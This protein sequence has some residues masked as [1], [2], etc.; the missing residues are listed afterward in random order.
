MKSINFYWSALLALTI[1]VS[2]CQNDEFLAPSGETVP[3][4]SVSVQGTT[5]PQTVASV[6]LFAGQTTDV[7][8]LDLTEVDTDKDGLNDAVSVTYSLTNGWLISE[9]HFWAGVTLA[10]MPQ[11]KNG[12]PQI[13]KFPY[14]I[15]EASGMSSYTLVIPFESLNY[16]DCE[17]TYVAAAHASVYSGSRKETA[18]AA[19]TEMN[20]KGSWATYFDFTLVDNNPPVVIGSLDEVTVEGCSALDV[21]EAAA[22]ISELEA[23]GLNVSDTRTPAE[24]LKVSSNDSENGTCPIVVTRTYTITDDCGNAT[25]VKQTIFVEDTTAPVLSGVGANASITAPAEPG[26][27]APVTSDECGGEV[28]LTSNDEVVISA[29]ETVITRTWTATDACGNSAFASQT[30]T[31]VN[32]DGQEFN[33]NSLNNTG[34]CTYQTETAFGGETAGDGNAWWFYFDGKGIQTI[35]AG[36]HYNVGTVE[37]KDGYL[38]I[39]LTDGWQ[40]QDVAESVKIQGYTSVP[41]KRPAAG[42]FTTYKGVALTV[43]VDAYPYYVIHLDVQKC[44]GNN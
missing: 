25:E 13:G 5:E 15:A 14:N 29:T 41:S 17:A 1:I 31:V 11:T 8:T 42:Q 23:L 21:P 39:S 38:L 30:I 32:A 37:L 22:S 44:N 4:K 10:D 40:L 35:W 6:T 43:P 18:W 34:D 27:T 26:F 2:S 16:T 28:S 33:N 36:Q 12:N 20:V 24:L 9:L 7:G 3:L 19:G